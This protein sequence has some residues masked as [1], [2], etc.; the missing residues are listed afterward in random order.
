[1]QMPTHNNTTRN[2]NPPYLREIQIGEFYWFVQMRYTINVYVFT[3]HD[4]M[5]T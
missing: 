3:W 2:E 5:F 4:D 1:M